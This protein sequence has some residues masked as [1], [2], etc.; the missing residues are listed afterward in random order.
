MNTPIRFAFAGFRHG[1]IFDLHQRAAAH[2][3]VIIVAAAEDDPTAREA[4]TGHGVKITHASVEALLEEGDFD[5][6]AVGDYF[7]RRGSLAVAALAQGKHVISDKPVCTSLI[8]W[9]EMVRLTGEK[10]LRVGCMLD[11]RACPAFA[12]MRQIIREGTIGEVQTVQTE[13]QHPLM[14][15][16]RPAWYFEKGKHGGTINDIGIHAFDLVPWLTGLEITRL[17]GARVWNGKAAWAPHFKDCGQFLLELENG[18]GLAG[19]VSYLAPDGTGYQRPQ[20]WRISVYGTKGFVEGS[21]ASKELVLATDEDS[22]LRQVPVQ[23]SVAGQ[24]LEDFLA[25]LRGQVAP[26]ALHTAAILKASRVALRVQ[27][28]ADQAG[29]YPLIH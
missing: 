29:P 2:P 12:T 22:A 8:E 20:Y 25:D 23:E 3:S 19:D 15:Q 11:L 24:Y 14:A 16:V 10:N 1:H 27:Q 4:A 6:L 7:G 13:S 21:S 28:A 9:E 18:A 17:V 26:G 5:V